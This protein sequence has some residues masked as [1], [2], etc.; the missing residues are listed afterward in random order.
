MQVYNDEAEHNR[1]NRIYGNVFHDN[2]CAGISVSS[3]ATGSVFKNNILYQNRGVSGD[4]QGDGPAQMLYREG[5]P[6]MV[7]TFNDII[8]DGPGQDVIQDEFGSGDTLASYESSHPAVFFDNVELDPLFADP[9]AHEYSLQGGSD[10]IDAGGF[11]T[12]TV[13]AG[14]GSAM[15][16]ADAG[17]FYDGFGI[18]GETGDIIQLEG[19]TD[20]AVVVAVDYGAN[21][22][23]LDRELSWSD[24]QGVALAHGGTAPDLGASEVP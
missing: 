21:T 19:E 9:S 15:A 5:L 18:S 1:D 4:C 20:T 8:N 17:Y 12:V 24:D 7:V 16:V 14:T 3:A 13:G 10:A 22:L 2:E 11:L 23:T 6:D